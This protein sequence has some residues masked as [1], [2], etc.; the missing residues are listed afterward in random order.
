M[1]GAAH[2]VTL[3]LNESDRPIW[4]PARGSVLTTVQLPLMRTWRISGPIEYQL[5]WVI[6]IRVSVTS[7]LVPLVLARRFRPDPTL[8]YPPHTDRALAI[9]RRLL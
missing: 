4:H 1:L 5:S 9:L 3:I 8:I 7:A 2:W 6:P